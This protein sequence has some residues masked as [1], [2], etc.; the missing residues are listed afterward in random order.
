MRILAL[1]VAAVLTPGCFYT[2]VI[3]VPPQAGIERVDTLPVVA[4]GSVIM[5]SARRSSDPDGDALS[6]TWRSSSCSGCGSLLGSGMGFSHM[7]VNPHADVRFELT[8]TDE[9]GA[10]AT[11]TL[12][13]QVANQA[14]AV[15]IVPQGTQNDDGSYTVGR[16][17]RFQATAVDP[18]GD[19]IAQYAF[20]LHPPPAA[21]P[22]DYRFEREDIA[23]TG[24][25][26]TSPASGRWR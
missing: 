20:V 10:I 15:T 6:Y 2:E 11:A 17:V 24:S 13:V 12:T 8:V 26:P 9:H 14:P 19:A 4:R 7:V 5:V 21:D 16:T 3:N 1:A 18:D 23:P 22:D 25:S